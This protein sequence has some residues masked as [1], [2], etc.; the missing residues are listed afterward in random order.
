MHRTLKAGVMC[1]HGKLSIYAV[2]ART[3]CP[4]Y[5]GLY[6]VCFICSGPSEL[7]IIYRGDQKESFDCTMPNVQWNVNAF[8]FQISVLF[9]Q[10][11]ERPKM[12]SRK[13]KASALFPRI[14]RDRRI[15]ETTV[16]QSAVILNLYLRKT[17]SR[18]II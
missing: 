12:A 18:E 8:G 6:E 3:Q 7:S 16:N 15:K 2:F 14:L 10:Y 5:R 1:H 11:E 13:N 17:Q 9:F 4:Y